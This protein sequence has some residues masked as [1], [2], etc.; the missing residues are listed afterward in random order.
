MQMVM[1]ASR[2]RH[3]IR[4]IGVVAA[5]LMVAAGT[6]G[7]GLIG[8][9]AAPA[10][11][12]VAPA[13]LPQAAPLIDAAATGGVTV[14]DIDANIR[15]WGAKSAADP[16][17][18]IS[19]TNLG[20]LYL[21][22]ARLTSNLDDYSRAAAATGRALAA[23]PGYGPARALDATV[24]FAA[25]DF[26]GALSAARSLQAD[27]PG[28]AD[29]L[30]VIGDASLELGD[31]GAARATYASLAALTPGPALDV[32]I[33]RLAYVSGDPERALEIARRARDGAVESGVVDPAFFE[34]QL[35]EFARLAGDAATARSAFE[36]TLGI[37]P[38]HLAA[39]VGLARIDAATGHRAAAIGHLERAVAIAPQPEALALLGDLLAAEGQEAAAKT[40]FDTVRLSAELGDLAGAVYDRQLIGFELDHGGAS[41]ATLT[42]ARASASARPDAAGHDLVAWAL[43]RLGRHDE[44]RAES[45]IALG[46]GIVDARIMFHAGAIALAQGHGARGEALLA[47]A[48]DLGPALDPGDRAEAE[49][50]LGR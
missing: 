35:G 29:A 23:F 12:L 14:A 24:R 31:L 44:A 30:A 32:R 19:A 6:Y 25:H 42:A 33:A 13:V 16:N 49:R 7:A 41:E 17:D 20:I 28:D 22:R 40:Q 43:Y 48:I 47:Q 9:A 3:R 4:P 46:T 34:Y 50:L 5:A 2:S 37:R 8:R 21:G 15:T 10:P 1:N 38:A 26:D 18:Y 11:T 36:A 39:L 27:A 45:D